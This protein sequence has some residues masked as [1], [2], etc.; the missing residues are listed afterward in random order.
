MYELQKLAKSNLD[1]T[2]NE[3]MNSIF[4]FNDIENL[5]FNTIFAEP[6]S[7]FSVLPD[8]SGKKCGSCSRKI[9]SNVP[10]YFC[11]TCLKPYHQKCSLDSKEIY[12]NSSNWQCDK[13]VLQEFPFHSLNENVFDA[14]RQGI[15]NNFNYVLDGLPSFTI[16]SLLDKMPAQKFTTDE[17]L[18]NS[19][20]SKYYSPTEFI[21]AKFSK[22]A[23][24]M[25]HLNIAS[26]QLHIDELRNLLVLLQHPF[27]VICIT[28]TR[29]HDD[30]PL[31]NVDIE[32]YDFRHTP[33]P[34][35]CGG[36]GMYIKSSLEYEYLE[37]FSMCQENIAESF[38]IEIKNPHKKNLI[39]GCI[40]RHHSPIHTF[41]TDFFSP[42]LG[43]ISK[44]KRNF[45]LLGDF[46]IDLS[47]YGAHNDTENFYDLISSNG[48]R[49]LIL[50]PSRV[51]S[52]TATLIDNIF[53]NNLDCFSK[54]GNITCSISDHFLQFV[55]IDIFDRQ[56]K[57]NILKY[58]RNWRLF[59][60][61]EFKNDLISTDWSEVITPDTKT[62]DS[63]NLFYYKIEKLID[64]MAPIKKL[65]KKEIGL[66]KS[67]WVTSG[68][69]KSIKERD[70]LYKSFTLEKDPSIKS[71]LRKS[72]KN[73]RNLIVKL[74]RSSKK[75][76]FSNFFIEHNKNIKKTWEAIRDLI[77]VSKKSSS[78]IQKILYNG[79]MITEN[80]GMANIINSF[81]TN[82]GSSVEAKIPQSKNTFRSYLGNS[83]FSSFNPSEIS[84]D[85]IAKIVNDLNI[86]K[87]CGPFNIPSKI[88]KE[89]SDIL[90]PILTIVINKSI[91]EGV[92]PE[93]LKKALVCPIYKK[94]TKLT[95]QTIALFLFFQILV[96]YLKEQCII[97]LSSSLIL[98][99]LFMI[100]NLVS[101]RNTQLVMH[102]LVLSKTFVIKWT[103]RLFHV[104]YLLT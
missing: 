79:Q 42:L 10:N 83:I 20:S 46:N 47:K 55:S 16:K 50:Q 54:G 28:E 76:Y 62:N 30:K 103:I 88:L 93:L 92:F 17:F 11:K 38:F 24:S 37:K 94:M 69:L 7:P 44:S 8:C 39:I 29:L 78:K 26:L 6:D 81:Y 51:T 12:A 58:S 3:C 18:T 4:P 75:Q 40:Y 22:K 57:N 68:I 99:T 59:N 49:P 5:E 87:A 43:K 66:K 85:E 27:D 23:F 19:I 86:S 25:I 77:N 65:T 32:G 95:V 71:S 102:C 45:A 96:S 36:A 2:C 34:T 33:T 97:K 98:I 90:S 84:T 60:K 70:M 41:I 73:Y 31:A 89:F 56:K 13:C 64:E 104:V 35:P 74:L 80:K 82:I 15:S 21:D 91:K 100:Y 53:C 14:T 1:W 61:N 101:A 72:Y 63:F 67:P 52:K 48:F 9:H